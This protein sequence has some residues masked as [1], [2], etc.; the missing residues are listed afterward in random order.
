MQIKL[1]NRR[2]PLLWLLVL[3]GASLVIG[4]E[5]LSAEQQK[6]VAETQAPSLTR[7]GKKTVNVPLFQPSETISADKAVSFPTD[8]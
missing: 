6:P 1:R 2:Q 4:Q 3:L 8:I 5:L 7:D